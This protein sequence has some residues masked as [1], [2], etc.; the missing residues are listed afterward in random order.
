MK[1]GHYRIHPA[2]VKL[3]LYGVSVSELAATV[4]L[5][6]SAVSLQLAG[7]TRLSEPVRA[8]IVQLLGPD[9]AADV[10]AAVPERVD[11]VAA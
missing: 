6:T 10:I 1:R 4:G 9:N 5:S 2:R 8:G 3:N 7:V 11:Q